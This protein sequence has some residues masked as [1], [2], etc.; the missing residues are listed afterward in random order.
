MAKSNTNKRKVVFSLT[1]PA[2]QSVA[3]VADF[4][5]WE[6]KP[7]ALKRQKGGPWKTTVALAP[8]SYEYRF[9]VDGQWQDDPTCQTLRP[10]S[11]GSHNCVCVVEAAT[12]EP[13]KTS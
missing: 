4:T 3:L 13:A 5:E 1:A 8:G 11:Y 10:N 7:V 9:L 2:A 6:K 12:E